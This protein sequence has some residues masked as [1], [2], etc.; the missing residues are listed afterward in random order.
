M[1]EVTTVRRICAFLFLMLLTSS[2]FAQNFPRAEVFGGYSL[3]HIDTQGVTGS[4]LD[5]LCNNAFGTGT[6]PPGSFQVHTNF[7]GWNGAVQ[8]NLNRWVGITGDFSGH[9]G[10]PVTISSQ[11]QA[12]L[13]QNGITGLPPKATSY[14]Y[15]F[16]PVTSSRR[17]R[18]TVFAH[19]LF[20]ANDLSATVKSASV[21]GFAIP[22]L[23]ASDT[24]FAA[25]FG[26]GADSKIAKNLA[27][28]IQADYLLTTHNFSGGVQGVA[29]HQNNVRA[30]VGIVYSF[31]AGNARAEPSQSPR[32]TAVGMKIPSL[33]ITVTL[34]A[35]SG[36]EITDEAP[37]G[38]AALAGVH[39]GDVIN[40]VDGKRV[41]TPMELAAELTKRPDGD[42]VKI[43]FLI[44]GQWQTDKVL[45]LGNH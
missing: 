17:D 9:Y 16:G 40:A 8:A 19:A 38:I 39:V 20:G 10:T 13:M 7:N 44:R 43:G 35:N 29:A 4:T 22:G 18:L 3:L 5:A 11:A 30:S 37:N 45:L 15:L 1:K 23:T 21:K 31:G 2:A 26:G 36:A 42:K 34:G 6:C 28:R 14:S 12:I 25:A 41:S 27:F 32:A 24:A 33:G